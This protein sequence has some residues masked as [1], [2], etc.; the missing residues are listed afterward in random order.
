MGHRVGIRPHHQIYDLIM[1]I[2]R[3]ITFSDLFDP[4]VHIRSE[5]VHVDFT[6]S[7]GFGRSGR[8]T[9]VIVHDLTTDLANICHSQRTQ[10]VKS[11]CR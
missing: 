4:T 11:R 9:A 1:R 6:H 5:S 2:C 3:T 10:L 8:E 7:L